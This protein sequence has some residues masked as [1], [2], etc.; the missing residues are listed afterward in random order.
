MLR[1]FT[2]LILVWP[3]LPA[4]LRVPFQ[5]EP[6]DEPPQ[7]VVRSPQPGQAI[8]GSIPVVA[9][10]PEAEIQSV[11]ISFS[12]SDDERET[13]FFIAEVQEPAAS[14]ELATWDTSTLTDGNY[15]LRLS[16]QMAN[17]ERG[18][19]EVSGLRVRN[20]TPLETSTPVLPVEA[21]VGDGVQGITAAQ[22][23]VVGLANASPDPLP[24]NPAQVSYQAVKASLGKGALAAG[25]GFLL[26]GMYRGTR[27]TIRKRREA[28]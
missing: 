2:F 19:V 12:Y 23:P 8:Q 7:V 24:D 26:L 14:G 6:D 5:A 4:L 9:N 3:A 15:S 18:N 17:G 1:L 11:E 27:Q 22:T 28:A 13:W 25:A 10:L 16:V 21:G 20:Y